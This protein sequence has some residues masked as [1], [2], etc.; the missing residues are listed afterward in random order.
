MKKEDSASSIFPTTRRDILIVGSFTLILLATKGMSEAHLSMLSLPFL[1]GGYVALAPPA[2]R[3]RQQR[4][5]HPILDGW[6]NFQ[7]AVDIVG[8]KI[9]LETRKHWSGLN[10]NIGR[11]WDKLASS[12]VKLF[13]KDKRES[14]K[15]LD[16]VLR[17]F[18]SVLSGS[19]VDTAQLLKACRAH[20]ILMK[21][22]GV[23]LKVVAK[24]METNL[25]KAE[26]LFKKMPQEGKYL[27]SLL[28]KEREKGVHDGNRLRNES[29]AMGL[30][31]V[32]R[33]LAFQLDLYAAVISA[34]GRHPKAAAMDAYDK[35]LAPYHGWLLQK[36]FPLSLSQI[37]DRRTFIAKFGGRD[38]NLDAK[39]EM[40]I[41][42][43]LKTLVSVWKPIIDQ[44]EYEFARLDLEDMR[45]V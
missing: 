45:L 21:S 15:K 7:H 43:K 4:R 17:E 30:L 18:K 40:E 24:D 37:P 31:W 19:E 35:T 9:Q 23:A 36:A 33:S 16:D 22:G 25:N 38:S 12:V 13:S 10:D 26:S 11:E 6:A 34:H 1:R 27:A 8:S 29:A 41:V 44:W 3:P 42:K 2:T 20:V 32:R 14:T 39:S 5:L 28:E